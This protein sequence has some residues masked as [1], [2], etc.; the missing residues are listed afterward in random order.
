MDENIE[1]WKNINNY[2]G[3]YQVSN[4][5]RIRTLTRALVNSLGR[6]TLLEGIIL[7][8]NITGTDGRPQIVLK[9]T[10]C[11]KKPKNFIISRLVALHFLENP[12]NLPVVHH[13][14]NNPQ[15]NKE[16]NLKWVSYKE[17]AEFA[18]ELGH[19]K[20]E[21]CN[22]KKP[23][24]THS[25]IIPEYYKEITIKLEG[26]VWKEAKGYEDYHI[27]NYGR[28]KSFKENIEGIII[29]PQ[30][31]KQNYLSIK[32]SSNNIFKRFR[33][34]R[35]VALN[36]IDNFN[37]LPAVNHKDGN[38]H[39]NHVSNLEWITHK[40]NMKHGKE[41]LL[42]RNGNYHPFAKLNSDKVINIKRL[43]NEGMSKRQLSIKYEVDVKTI[44]GI[45]NGVTWR[46]I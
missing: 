15:N 46:H 33:I 16:N 6:K 22:F 28:I 30:N 20:Q 40:D 26:E 38:K 5:G 9:N 27:S 1:I 19:L 29:L 11:R 45:I 7:T 32:L 43:F 31:N 21:R 10:S 23:V 18:N 12:L 34:H 36:F 42:F 13:I 44:R 8:N 39:N 4:L 35:L 3:L 24:K 2:E 17:N 25:T 37:N 41:L 14:D